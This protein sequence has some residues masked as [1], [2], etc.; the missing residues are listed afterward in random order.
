M[1]RWTAS[2]EGPSAGARIAGE[3]SP[4]NAW[5]LCPMRTLASDSHRS[6]TPAPADE[7]DEPESVCRSVGHAGRGCH[8]RFA[9][10]PLPLLRRDKSRIAGSERKD[11]TWPRAGVRTVQDASLADAKPVTVTDATF[12]S[13]VER[14]PLPV[15]LDVW[16]A[17]CGPCRMLAPVIDELASQFVGR[18]RSPSSTRTRI[19]RQRPASTSVASRPSWCSRG[20]ARSTASSACSPRPRSCT[21][22]SGRPTDAA[23]S[24]RRERIPYAAMSETSS[25][26][27]KF[28]V[29]NEASCWEYL[30]DKP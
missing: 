19:P 18:V 12:A 20:A 11:R 14:S 5:R 15:V 9:V 8:G 7:P 17:W 25:N 6:S 28:S 10:N 3:T 30:V 4:G 26:C 24:S 27:W 22:S 2:S 21:G 29:I 1:T 23:P 13:E 16:A